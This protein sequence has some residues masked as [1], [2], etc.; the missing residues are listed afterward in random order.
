MFDNGLEYDTLTRIFGA[1]KTMLNHAVE[2][3]FIEKHQF[4]K[5]SL[6]KPKPKRT[7]EDDEL[8]SATDKRTYFSIMQMRDFED[9]LDK[10]QEKYRQGRRNSRARGKPH[11]KSLDNVVFV[12][13]VKPWLLVMYYSGLR[14]G[15]I[16]GLRWNNLKF[17]TRKITKVIEKLPIIMNNQ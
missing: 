11:L 15:D 10:Y 12:D 2:N 5:Y 8:E 14:P 17:E 7:D 9:A 4:N 13:H 6:E 1:L 3:Q 16:F